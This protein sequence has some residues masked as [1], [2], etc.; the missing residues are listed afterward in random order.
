MPYVSVPKDL[1]KV[2]V[3]VLFGLT[4][5]QLICFALAAAVGIPSYLL[6]RG[7]I[8]NTAAVLLMIAIM[9][10]F[11]FLALYERD[12]LSAEKV[13]RNFIRTRFLWPGK[14]VYRTENLYKYLSQE[15][16]IIAIQDKTTAATSATKH[17]AGKK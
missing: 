1:T 6:T 16:K 9:L 12:G 17:R 2:K 10:P 5:R 3:R 4:K 8:G 11:F 13:M 14:R 15:G 7:V